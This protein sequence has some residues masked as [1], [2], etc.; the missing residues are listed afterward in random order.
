MDLPYYQYLVTHQHNSKSSFISIQSR[1]MTWGYGWLHV[2]LGVCVCI[3]RHWAQHLDGAP[4]LITWQRS[5]RRA[6]RVQC[7][8]ITSLSP[9]RTWKTWVRASYLHIASITLLHVGKTSFS[10]CQSRN[11]P[12]FPSNAHILWTIMPQGVKPELSPSPVS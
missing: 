2:W 8:M 9:E 7:T 10:V 5:W 12:S 1:N 4:S 11:I 3:F 6:P